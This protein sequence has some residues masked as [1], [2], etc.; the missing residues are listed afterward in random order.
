MAVAD[1]LV[2]DY[3]SVMFDFAVT[4]KP[5]LFL[6]PDLEEYAGRTRG[7]YLDLA[8]IAP[9]PLLDSTDDV[10]AALTGTVGAATPHQ[11]YAAFRERFAPWDDGAAAERVVHA[12]WDAEA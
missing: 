11:G 4:G 7:L 9:G 8:E 1:V 12:V 2:T 5:M 10:I 3:S 6:V